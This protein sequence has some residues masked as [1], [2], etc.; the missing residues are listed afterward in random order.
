MVETLGYITKQL[1]KPPFRQYFCYFE[2]LD[3]YGKVEWKRSM[4]KFTRTVVTLV[5]AKM[6]A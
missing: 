4:Q 1:Q 5:K 2:S 3:L 6:S